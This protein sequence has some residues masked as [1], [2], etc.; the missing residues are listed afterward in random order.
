[1][2]RI[3][4]KSAVE[5][6]KVDRYISLLDV[7]YQLDESIQ[8]LGVML[9]I[10]NGSQTYWKPNPGIAEKNRIN[11]ALITL[12]KDLKMP[13]ITQKVVKTPP[14]QYDSSDLV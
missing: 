2:Q 4:K 3:D 10:Q 13:K 1:M 8:K 9:K 5:K 12:E 11:S 14:S 6:E 7:F